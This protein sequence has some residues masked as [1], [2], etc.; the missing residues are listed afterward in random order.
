M[1]VASVPR[2]KQHGRDDKQVYH[3]G[4][5][6]GSSATWQTCSQLGHPVYL[7]GHA[8]RP[9]S[10]KTPVFWHA[11]AEL[12]RLKLISEAAC[13]QPLET[14]M[15]EIAISCDMSQFLEHNQS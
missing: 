8:A 10:N 3:T 9:K 13:P 6:P 2:E 7:F 1:P 12:R 4:L 15:I 11:L 14:L 5:S